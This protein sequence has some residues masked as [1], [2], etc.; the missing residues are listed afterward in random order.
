MT[1]EAAAI[2]VG[3]VWADRD[4]R[5]A[6]RTVRVDEASAHAVVLTVVTSAK[7]GGKTGHRTTVSRAAFP[8]RYRLTAGTPSEGLD[9]AIRRTLAVAPHAP[10]TAR[11]VAAVVDLHQPY[12]LT[13]ADPPYEFECREC[14][15]EYPCSTVRV[16]ARELG[17][18]P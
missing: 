6:G 12:R 14:E 17:V 2:R 11:S 9:A 5:E 8:K 15:R 13:M 1:D 16:V 18:T 3:Q 4:P 7:P 10:S